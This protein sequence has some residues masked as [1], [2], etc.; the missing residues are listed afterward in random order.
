MITYSSKQG[1]VYEFTWDY[2]DNE[3]STKESITLQLTENDLR[4]LAE[5]L[6]EVQVELRK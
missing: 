1:K 3:E 2:Y 6:A 5:A 4:E